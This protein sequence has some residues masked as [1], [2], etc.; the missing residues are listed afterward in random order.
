MPIRSWR[1][2]RTWPVALAAVLSVIGAATSAFALTCSVSDATLSFASPSVDWLEG[3]VLS[4][5]VNESPV[6]C[7]LSIVEDTFQPNDR[8]QIFEL[9]SEQTSGSI[10]VLPMRTIKWS[11]RLSNSDGFGYRDIAFADITVNQPRGPLPDGQRE[12]TISNNTVADLRTFAH[13]VQTPGATV[14]IAGDA[15]LNLS[16]LDELPLAPG[17]K[18]L[19]DRRVHPRGP[20]LYTTTFPHALFV[21]P[22]SSG[23]HERISGLRLDGVEPDDPFDNLGDEDDPCGE[24]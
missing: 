15:D 13:A 10:A 12:V 4:Y 11:L 21:I 8:P 18:I 19:G 24:G 7:P 3:V 14:R 20:R 23:S 5:R 2:G 16:G 1:R 22:P 17:V 9:D 6:H